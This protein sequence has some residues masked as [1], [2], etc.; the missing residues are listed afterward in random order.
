[1]PKARKQE[2]LKLYPI[3]IPEVIRLLNTL[4]E[5]ETDPELKERIECLKWIV[6]NIYGNVLVCEVGKAAP[7]VFPCCGM[8]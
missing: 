6:G 7:Y 8:C 5:R 3:N 2:P 1:M 4:K